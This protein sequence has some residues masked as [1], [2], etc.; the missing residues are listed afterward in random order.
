MCPPLQNKLGSLLVLNLSSVVRK[1]FHAVA[2]KW[3]M[4]SFPCR[5]NDYSAVTFLVSDIWGDRWNSL[6]THLA[7]IWVNC[8]HVAKC[9][10]FFLFTFIKLT[11]RPLFKRLPHLRWSIPITNSSVSSVCTSM[12]AYTE[13]WCTAFI[14]CSGSM[15]KTNELLD[16]YILVK[17]P[18]L[19][20]NFV[21]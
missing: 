20:S 8:N 19:L 1:S 15:K 18:Y 3:K 4:K 12:H 5:Q 7:L 21:H 13:R 14:F 9:S 16:I 6:A 11:F 10:P 2:M 17:N